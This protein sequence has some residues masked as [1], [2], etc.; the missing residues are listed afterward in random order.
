LSIASISKF[1]TSN[2][3]NKTK[4]IQFTAIFFA[5]VVLVTS[6][7]QLRAETL[8]DSILYL[9]KNQKQ[10]LA[11]QAD[12]DAA[13]ERVET[14]WGAWYPEISVTTNWG[15]EK[16]NK[17]S[18]TDD[19]EEHPR[20]IGATVT[21]NIWDFGSTNSAIDSAKLTLRR[22]TINLNSTRQ[23]I[24]LQ[25]IEAHMNL[26]RANKVYKF[27][28]SSA[29]NIR[30][31]LKLEDARVQRGGGLATD[32]LQAKGQLAGAQARENS[33]RSGLTNAINAYRRFFKAVPNK[34]E[35]MDDP[36]V[37]FEL[38]PKSEEEM[39]KVLFK[40]NLGLKLSK[41]DAELLDQTINKTRADEFFPK[42]NATASTKAKTDVGGTAGS[43]T[44]QLFKIE[45]SYS[46]NL[47]LIERNTLMAS[48]KD[49]LAG[50]ERYID[51]RFSFEQQ[52]RDLWSNYKRDKENSEFLKNQA[53]IASE[54]LEL[55][56][57]ERELG[58]RTLMDVLSGETA[59]INA[60]S[61]AASTETDLK[62]DAFRILNIIGLLDAEV[63][64][65]S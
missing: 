52:A 48:K 60:N 14:A 42:I 64:S 50:T 7:V 41:I 61:D 32:V 10:I 12:V 35:D 18:G 46:L 2:L 51:A 40:N 62:L 24:I 3:S 5:M 4:N 16:Q 26:I 39:L 34:I 13:R 44:E 55:A 29:E 65:S 56:R 27:A 9:S 59:L 45:L 37:P 15:R 49:H 63:L 22:S 8:Y 33:T 21:Q 47:G 57:K 31:Q 6:S 30:G 11:A 19:S 23:A 17:G 20:E 58:N 25:G 38:L 1:G 36:R 28:K 43:S 54:F 53:N